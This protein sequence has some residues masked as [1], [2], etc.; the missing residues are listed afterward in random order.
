MLARPDLAGLAPGL[1]LFALC[2]LPLLLPETATAW[3]EYRR[4]AVLD[5]EVW[6]LWSGHFVHYSSAHALLDGL[7]CLIFALALR[8]L[9]Y[10]QG[11]MIRLAVIVPLLSLVL[12]VVVTDMAIYRGASGVAM[13]LLAASWLALWRSKPG[14]RPGLLVLAA[15]ILLKLAADGL[16]YAPIP[17]SLPNEIRIAWQVHLA[18]LAAGL[19]MWRGAGGRLGS[20][21]L[22][23]AA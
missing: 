11:L 20:C 22:R 12:L 15:A 19:L 1:S 23:Q 4:E 18:G 17:S 3:L 6:R 13:A 10:A 8:Q 2:L 16:A 9:G 5:G 21:D 14:W 7:A